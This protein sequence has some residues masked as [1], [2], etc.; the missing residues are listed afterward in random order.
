MRAG[1]PHILSSELDGKSWENSIVRVISQA[2][3]EREYEYTAKTEVEVAETE[4]DHS[5]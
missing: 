2:A 1:Q 4:K 5:Y 3:S